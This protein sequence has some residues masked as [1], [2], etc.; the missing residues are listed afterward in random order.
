MRKSLG[1]WEEMGVGMRFFSFV[2]SSRIRSKLAPLAQETE[3]E[4]RNC[5]AGATKILS[6]NYS[7]KKKK[8]AI[9]V[10]PPLV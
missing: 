3:G 1:E 7:M 5:E 2:R 4:R 8:S 9:P 10:E 6:A